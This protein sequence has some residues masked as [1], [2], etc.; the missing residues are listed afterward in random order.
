MGRLALSDF[1]FNQQYSRKTRAGHSHYE[2]KKHNPEKQILQ[3]VK[4]S[5]VNMKRAVRA[6]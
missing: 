3:I 5:F 2:V 1:G 4:F 6:A